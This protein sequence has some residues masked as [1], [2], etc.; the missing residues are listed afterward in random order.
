M[1]VTLLSDPMLRASIR[2]AALPDEDVVCEEQAG[3]RA[4][5]LGFPRLIVYTPEDLRPDYRDV[6]HL[7]SGIPCLALTHT[8]TK[9]W[10]ASRR[11]SGFAVTRIDDGANRLRVLMRD[12]AG[13]VPW[14]DQVFANLSKVS[15][16]SLPPAFRGFARRVLEY[17]ARYCD[18]YA[19][20]EL[21]DLTPGALKGRFRRRGLASPSDHLRWLR[22][23]AAGHLLADQRA[24]TLAAA[25]RLGISSDGNFCR[26]LKNTTGLRPTR[27][28]DAE[29]TSRLLVDFGMQFLD[30]A[31]RSSWMA[32]D[33]LFL[34]RVA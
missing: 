18:L 15:G 32:L 12:A 26:W 22:A 11:A 25:Y 20:S 14:V 4:I 29:G 6:E 28:R 7:G 1:I 21:C 30:P 24:T 16:G 9:A 3:L 31:S 23:L 8:A 34:R 10:E 2:R 13:T 27:L 5:R 19:L 33:D 17:P